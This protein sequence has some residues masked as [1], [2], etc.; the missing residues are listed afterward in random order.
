M[1][2]R[3][4]FASL[5]VIGLVACG[6]KPPPKPKAPPPPPDVTLG[7]ACEM[8]AAAGQKGHCGS[9][10][11][12]MTAGGASFCAS[13]CPC[14]AGGSCV[15]SAQYPE[16]CL[17]S[18]E[19][20]A[21]CGGG[22]LACNADHKVCAPAGMLPG[23]P[24]ACGEAAPPKKTFGAVTPLEKSDK[25]SHDPALA[26]D[27]DGNLVEVHTVG[28]ADSTLSKAVPL[29]RANSGSPS[30]ATDRNGKLYLAALGWNG[31]A[32]ASEMVLGV[33][34]SEDGKTWNKA[35]PAFDANADC[36]GNA[37][38]CLEKPFIV[39]GSARDNPK[40]D[41]ITTLYWSNVTSSLRST[42]STDGGATFSPSVLVGTGAFSD[43]DV[44]STG[45]L[46]VVYVSGPAAGNRLGDTGNGVYYTSSADGATFSPATRIS[47]ESDAAPYYF[48]SP[49]VIVDVGRKMLYAVYVVGTPDGKW[50]VILATSKDGGASWPGRTKVN[51]DA[52]CATHMLPAAALEPASGKIHVI[53]IE[54]RT[55]TGSVAYSACAPSGTSCAKNETVSDAPFAAFGYG[56]RSATTLGDYIGLVFNAK[57]KTLHAVWA[58]P[59]GEGGAAVSQL[60]HASAKLK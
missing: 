60:F 43:A 29:E 47:S 12:C 11:S 56:R 5:L 14:G 2:L 33:A 16:T 53:W 46:H 54:N 44:T 26:F 57:Q 4:I 1:S 22:G 42:R 20:D 59:V 18:C 41:V 38:G 8:G 36:A 6:G 55:G 21:D 28:G 49:R 37:A 10:L 40:I 51:D 34:T 50:D 13:A 31:G 7:G 48:S 45:K 24:P 25:A 30:I 58:Q 32:A 17:K 35:V 27:H 15:A 19:A 39:I 9:G 52:S 3:P 23:K